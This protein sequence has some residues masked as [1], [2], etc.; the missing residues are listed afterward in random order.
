MVTYLKQ[1]I[2]SNW[3]YGIF[4][5]LI[6]AL[7]ILVLARGCQKPAAPSPLQ[8]DEIARVVV[9]GRTVT[10]TTPKGTTKQFV[11]DTAKVTVKT[12]G[13]ID[14]K[15][16]KLGIKMELGGGFAVTPSRLKLELDTRIAYAWKFSLHGGLTLDPAATKAIDIARPLIF[17]A[18][19][20]ELRWTPNTSVWIGRELPGDWCGGFRVRF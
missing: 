17:V 2:K 13:T 8:P 4:G 1:F 11:P 12:D 19:P 18:Y 7:T 14:V 5:I 15:V 9:D 6:G 20:L 16:Q 10:V 3:K